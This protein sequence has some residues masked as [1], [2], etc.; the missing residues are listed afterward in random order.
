MLIGGGGTLRF[1]VRYAPSSNAAAWESMQSSMSQNAFVSLCR[2]SVRTEDM[3]L[4]SNTECGSGPRSGAVATKTLTTP[5]RLVQRKRD[6]S[7]SG[8]PQGCD[9]Q[10]WIGWVM[11]FI[12][13]KQHPLMYLCHHVVCHAE[14]VILFRKQGSCIRKYD[15]YSVENIQE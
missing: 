3:K 5:E 9:R 14:N 10:A 15:F 7:T 8:M 4:V 11:L 13:R 12:G 1:I 6:I 2:F